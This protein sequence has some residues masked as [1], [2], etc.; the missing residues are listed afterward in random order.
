MKRLFSHYGDV[1]VMDTTFNITTSYEHFGWKMMSII[2]INGLG[3]S[4]AL[5]CILLKDETSYTLENTFK[6][7]GEAND[8]SITKCIL[9][10]KI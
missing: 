4:E 5:A 9:L 3:L 2:G 10:I 1:L 8:F 7:L 6:K